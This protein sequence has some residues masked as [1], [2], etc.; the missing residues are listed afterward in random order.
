MP[1]YLKTKVN[2]HGCV[3]SYPGPMNLLTNSVEGKEITLKTSA[4]IAISDG[5]KAVVD[6]GKGRITVESDLNGLRK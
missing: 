4:N 2:I 1:D 6:T 5:F 3:F